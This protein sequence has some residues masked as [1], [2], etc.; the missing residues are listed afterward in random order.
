MQTV[1]LFPVKH[2][3]PTTV[4]KACYPHRKISL[5]HHRSP[6]KNQQKPP[7]R[8]EGLVKVIV[9]VMHRLV[10][11][12]RNGIRQNRWKVTVLPLFLNCDRSWH[13]KDHLDLRLKKRNVW[14]DLQV[15]SFQDQIVCLWLYVLLAV[16]VLA[17]IEIQLV[18]S[19]YFV[20][21][22]SIALFFFFVCFA[23][24]TDSNISEEDLIPPPLPAKLRELEFSSLP[25]EN[26]SFLYSSRNS[27][28]TTLQIKLS[29][30][31]PDAEDVP[32]SPPPKPP[33]NKTCQ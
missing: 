15:G 28:R 29:T 16:L 6:I 7:K 14:V 32:P 30:P 5:E 23:D 20:A 12:E 4:Q 2:L 8:N 31:E 19:Y 18:S 22:T 21:K 3:R 33:R 26:T 9:L 27:V 1:V 11:V 25:V 10:V 13:Q 24:T 17:A